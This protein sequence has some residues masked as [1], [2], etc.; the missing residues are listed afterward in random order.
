MPDNKHVFD[1]AVVLGNRPVDGTVWELPE[2]VY[3][4][5]GLAVA[6]YRNNETRYIVV[7][8]KWTLNFD[9]LGIRQ[10]FTEYEKMAEYLESKGIPAEA[11]LRETV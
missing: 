1:A 10:Q 8:G 6:M 11:I 3:Q 5:L 7:A 4:S 2:H 9:I